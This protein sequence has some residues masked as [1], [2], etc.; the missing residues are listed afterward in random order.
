MASDQQDETTGQADPKF[1]HTQRTWK[2]KFSD[3]FAGIA[4][5]MRGQSSFAVHGTFL[6]LGIALGCFLQLEAWRWVAFLLTSS[7][8]LCLELI[9]SAIE[10]LAPAI[11]DRI[12]HRIDCALK[13]A[14]GAVLVAAI[15]SVIIGLIV[16]GPPL[17]QLWPR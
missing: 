10:S 3:A 15:F 17:W 2:R 5:G 9:N 11:T 4:I 14:S 8:V 13:I 12:D 1:V 6:I 16:F 7:L